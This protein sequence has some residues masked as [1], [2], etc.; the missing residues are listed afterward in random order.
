[1]LLDW[2]NFPSAKKSKH[3]QITATKWRLVSQ[4]HAKLKLLQMILGWFL[5]E[6]KIWETNKKKEKTHK[7]IVS[8]LTNCFWIPYQVIWHIKF[9]VFVN[10]SGWPWSFEVIF[11]DRKT[12]SIHKGDT[13]KGGKNPDFILLQDVKI[14]CLIADLKHELYWLPVFQCDVVLLSKSQKLFIQTV[15]LL[16]KSRNIESTCS[17]V[18]K[19]H[20]IYVEAG[21]SVNV[22]LRFIVLTHLPLLL[23]SCL[24][25]VT[26]TSQLQQTPLI[27]MPLLTSFKKFFKQT[28]CSDDSSSLKCWDLC[29][30]ASEKKW[31]YWSSTHSLTFPAQHAYKSL[32]I[33]KL[34]FE[35]LI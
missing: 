15:F 12:V 21:E 35:R 14:F 28:K 24:L 5:D 26:G 23:H 1:M 11:Q 31:Q 4:R 27:L 22:W 17:T 29:Y 32:Y 30:S 33:A 6:I 7:W 19:T 16:S 13:N 10:F 3:W 8:E 18:L 34:A 9:W 2:S 20:L 25:P